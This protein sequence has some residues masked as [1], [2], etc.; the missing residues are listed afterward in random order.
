MNYERTLYSKSRVSFCF[1]KFYY[2]LYTAME[3]M[4]NPDD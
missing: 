3:V 2:N 4:D 1:M